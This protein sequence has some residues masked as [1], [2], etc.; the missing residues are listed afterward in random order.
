[1]QFELAGFLYVNRR[2]ISL[3]RSWLPLPLLYIQKMM[4]LTFSMHTFV[5]EAI[6]LESTDAII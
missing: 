4:S 1:M 3:I 2:K 6:Q 5:L